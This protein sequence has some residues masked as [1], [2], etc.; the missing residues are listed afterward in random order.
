MAKA[1]NSLVV[2][3]LLAAPSPLIGQPAAPSP[4]ADL[5]AIVEA[6]RETPAFASFGPAQEQRRPSL[7]FASCGVVQLLR[8]HAAFI[9][10]G[11]SRN[12]FER[13]RQLSADVL[14]CVPDASRAGPRSRSPYV[15]PINQTHFRANGVWITIH[16]R[17]VGARGGRGVSL[18]IEPAPTDQA[19]G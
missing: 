15:P 3:A 9:C 2:A 7:G 14:R 8:G 17:P 11:E 16:E 1:R 5:Q 10:T 18:H 13:W 4:C 19:G 6:A 12:S